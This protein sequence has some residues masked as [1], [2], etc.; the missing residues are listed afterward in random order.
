MI[1]SA[2]QAFLLPLKKLRISV[3][4]AIQLISMMK[5]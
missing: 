1:V 2:Y 3:T 4:T 5:K